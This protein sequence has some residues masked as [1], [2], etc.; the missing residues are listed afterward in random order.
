MFAYYYYEEGIGKVPG[1]EK[2][3]PDPGNC[4]AAIRADS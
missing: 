4:C 2:L 3:L 1:K